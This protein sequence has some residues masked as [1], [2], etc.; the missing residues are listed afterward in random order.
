LILL[1][2]SKLSHDFPHV[3]SIKKVASLMYPSCKVSFLSLTFYSCFSIKKKNW[4]VAIQL[5][6]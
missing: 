2:P 4:H 3:I 5:F 6:F 1:S